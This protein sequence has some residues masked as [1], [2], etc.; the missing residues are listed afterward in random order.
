MVMLD[1]FNLRLGTTDLDPAG[2]MQKLVEGGD[3][4]RSLEYIMA[5]PEDDS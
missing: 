4:T 2:I 5:L 1:G 3:K